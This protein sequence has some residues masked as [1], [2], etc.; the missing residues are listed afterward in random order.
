MR[1]HILSLTF[2]AALCAAPVQAQPAQCGPLTRVF[3]LDL[4][5]HP[6]GLRYGV[7]VTVNG[8][9][10]TFL[11][12]TGGAWSQLS[13]EAAAE[14]K[15][16]IKTASGVQM[17]DMYGNVVNGQYVTADVGI[18]LLTAK[19]TDLMVSNVGG[20]D[21]IFAPDFMMNYDVELDFAGRKMNYF[22][23]N[24]CE[25]RVVYWPATAL[26]VVPFRGWN[27]FRDTHMTVP[28][29]LNGHEIIA[30][31]DTG[32]TGTTLH[33]DTAR[34]LFG[35]TPDSPGAVPLGTMGK[36]EKKVFGWTFKT[37]TMGGITI[38]NPRVRVIPDLVGG[39]GMDTLAAD[40]HVR[41][42]TDNMAP[43]MLIG[44]DVLRQLRV[45]IASKEKK[46]YVTAATPAAAAAAQ[47]AGN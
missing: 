42:I 29:S 23:T 11:L 3:A 36:T 13:P 24:H 9:P 37:L 15:L 25:G 4:D 35:L 21:G 34:A 39:R 12:D 20:M 7:P 6:S 41:R 22:L 30:T 26:A 5:M 47:P 8:K 18:G 14:L 43:T 31:I 40:S 44:M 32:A 27:S 1:T 17:F 16:T 33:E 10:K 38:T 46:L 19:N 2:A 45:Y 28:V